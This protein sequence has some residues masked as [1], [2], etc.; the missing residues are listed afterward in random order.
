MLLRQL[1]WHTLNDLLIVALERREEHSVTIDDDKAKLVVILEKRK[2]RLRFKTVLASVAEY[3]DGSERFEG[4]L[5][6]LLGV[7][8]LHQ[9]D[10]AEDDETVGR[11]VLVKLQL[12]SSRSDGRND[13]LA[14]LTRLDGLGSSQFLRQELH[15]LIQW[16][17]RRNV[18]RHKRSSISAIKG[19]KHEC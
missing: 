5:D 10:S 16:V 9:N 18:Q 2:Q 3:I 7:A 8:V 12:L 19:K 14:C 1:D 6:L 4:N 11:D 15:M 17:A 13:G